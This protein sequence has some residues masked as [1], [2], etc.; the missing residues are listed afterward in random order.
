MAAGNSRCWAQARFP[1]SDLPGLPDERQEGWVLPDKGEIDGVAVNAHHFGET[2]REGPYSLGRTL[3]HE[4][5]HFLGLYHTWG[6]NDHDADGCELDD[7]CTDT[8][9]TR[10]R[11]SG[12]SPQLA[13]D[14]TPAMIEN[15]MD[16][17]DDACMNIFTLEQINRM[18]TVFSQ[19]SQEK[20]T[21]P[22]ACQLIP[23]WMSPGEVETSVSIFP[24][25]GSGSLD[26]PLRKSHCR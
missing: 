13:C 7:F 26:H 6:P 20:I 22:I 2:G 9:P 14:G 10:A 23:F 4:L 8:P 24:N 17:T 3:T 16:Y 18:R 19:Q 25:P 5:G 1:E 21:N 12:C 11:L 15:Y